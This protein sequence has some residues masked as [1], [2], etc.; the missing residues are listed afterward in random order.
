MATRAQQ[1]AIHDER[2]MRI[3]ALFDEHH[4]RHEH[5]LQRWCPGW[6]RERVAEE[7]G[8]SMTTVSDVL[9][10]MRPTKT[11]HGVRP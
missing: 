11:N 7:C 5:N 2:A 3:C 8:C 10:R 4:E 1:R 9:A 6:S